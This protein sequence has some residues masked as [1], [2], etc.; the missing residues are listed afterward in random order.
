MQTLSINIFA[1][2]YTRP[3][4][5]RVCMRAR[6]LQQILILCAVIV[7]GVLVACRFEGLASTMVYTYYVQV[8]TPASAQPP[9]E[10][11]P[12]PLPPKDAGRSSD[13]TFAV[14]AP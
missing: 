2:E 1:P 13:S 5:L 8:Q 3:Q 12:A 7:L 4:P 9:E 14:N 10:A 11:M 6:T